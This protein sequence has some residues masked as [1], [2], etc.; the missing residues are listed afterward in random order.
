MTYQQAM[1]YL[2]SLQTGGIKMGLE[3]VEAVMNA[4]GN[5]HR[6][7]RVVHVAGTNG[8]GS[9]A[10]MIQ[11]MLTTAGYQV[12]S[13]TSP[14]FPTIRHGL[15]I[16]GQPI[17]QQHFADLVA[18]IRQADMAHAIGL[19]E[20][21]TLTAAALLHFAQ[22]RVELCVLECGLGGLTDATNICPPPLAAVITPVSLDH[23]AWLGQ[24]IE[25]IAPQKCGIIKAPCTV[26][27]SPD[28]S[29][30]ALGIIYQTAAQQGLTVL[31]PNLAAAELEAET[32]GQLTFGYAG[33]R[34]TLPF[35]GDF[36]I[37]NALTAMET[38]QCLQTKG[39]TVPAEAMV[40]GLAAATL[41]CRQQVLSREPLILLDGAHNPQA[42]T[43]L[44][45]T[46]K[47]Q[48]GGQKL[49]LVLG[50]LRD[51][52]T[53]FCANTLAP[54]CQHIF[55]CTPPTLR[56]IPAE[57]LAAEIQPLPGVAVSVVEQPHEA[58]ELAKQQGHPVV[59]TGSF[60]LASMFCCTEPDQ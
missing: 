38:V 45:R 43:A 3:R 11:S 14:A 39:Y 21:E 15:T 6:R 40:A 8:K 5:P 56:A 29:P 37:G 35:S 50:M 28:Q 4:L 54:L 41:P 48:L 57:R 19:S 17:G 2:K 16:D 52:D 55:C 34:V 27:S 36:Q 20:F 7:L 26:V 53:A 18:K 60:Y 13:Y 23:T 59:V 10:R 24:T 25:E 49:T 33:Q 58:F 12:G 47:R 1:E 46:L 22:Q 9:V 42:I 31:V 51:K 32:F 44:A 30:E